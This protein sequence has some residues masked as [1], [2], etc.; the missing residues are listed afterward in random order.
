MARN[1]K[2]RTARCDANREASQMATMSSPAHPDRRRDAVLSVRIARSASAT[3]SSNRRCLCACF[4]VKSREPSG[5]ET[6]SVLRTETIELCKDG[7]HLSRATT[8]AARSSAGWCSSQRPEPRGDGPSGASGEGCLGVGVDACAALDTVGEAL[9]ASTAEERKSS[10]TSDPVRRSDARA[11]P[12]NRSHL[13]ASARTTCSGSRERAAALR[14]RSA[15]LCLPLCSMSLTAATSARRHPLRSSGEPLA[16]GGI[17]RRPRPRAR[18]F[19]ILSAAFSG[20]AGFGGYKGFWPRARG[21]TREARAIFAANRARSAARSTAEHASLIADVALMPPERRGQRHARRIFSHVLTHADACRRLRRSAL[22]RSSVSFWTSPTSSHMPFQSAFAPCTR[23]REERR[24]GE[25]GEPAAARAERAESSLGESSART[26]ATHAPRNPSIVA[27]NACPCSS[28]SRARVNG[29]R[30][31]KGSLRGLQGEGGARPHS[32]LEVVFAQ[33]EQRVW[34]SRRA[35][36]GRGVGLRVRPRARPRRGVHRFRRGR[37][38]LAPGRARGRG[39]PDR[40]CVRFAV[41][42]HCAE[43][44]GSP[45]HGGA[46]V[47]FLSALHGRERRGGWR[48]RRGRSQRTRSRLARQRGHAGATGGRC[49]PKRRA[50]QNSA[51]GVALRVFAPS[52][53]QTP[54]PPDSCASRPRVSRRVVWRRGKRGAPPPRGRRKRV[55]GRP[56]HSRAHPREARASWACDGRRRRMRRGRSEKKDARRDGMLEGRAPRAARQRGGGARSVTPGFR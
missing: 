10:L 28:S 23:A 56:A 2:A 1:K 38:A 47:R 14:W 16:E 39:R 19:S 27:C 15:H 55:L 25:P 40:G 54:R 26:R 17:F 29:D 49:N 21:E 22:S 5:V 34:V 41:S 20:G 11:A 8:A 37:A 30:G 52:R 24:E 35:S 46:G 31:R 4:P 44:Q 42:M 9:V 13:P 50:R 32:A 12:A 36:E 51:H 45:A 3:A 18:A 48:A 53:G 6:D 33:L 7:V 43:A